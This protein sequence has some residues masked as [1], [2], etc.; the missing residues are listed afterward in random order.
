MRIHTKEKWSLFF[1]A[2]FLTFW[3]SNPVKAQE[4]SDTNS[5]DG[6]LV[7]DPI[8]VE[9]ERTDRLFED[10]W[11]S[12]VIFT[13]E[14]LKESPGTETLNDV[15]RRIPNVTSQGNAT[16]TAPTIRGIDGTGPASGTLAFIGGTLP[17]LNY[18]I[19]GR[20]LSFNEAVFINGSI[21]DAQQVEIYRGPQSTLQGRN[22]IAGVIAVKTMDPS[23]D[24][25][26]I[27]AKAVGGNHDYRH[28][29]AA[30]GGPVVDDVLA[31]RFSGEH[32]AK[33]SF[34]DFQPFAS[35]SDPEAEKFSNARLKVLLQPG[36]NSDFQNLLTIAYKDAYAPQANPVI[37]PFDE[38]VPPS[39]LAAMPRFETKTLEGILDTRW[40]VNDFIQLSAVATATDLEVNRY[41]PPGLGSVEIE[42]TEYT[43]EPR[44]K[45]GNSAD[46]ISGFAAAYLFMADQDEY[47][48]FAGGANFTDETLT[49][50]VFGEVNLN[51]TDRL[52]LNFG[53]RYE[54][55]NRE[56]SG[57]IAI[58]NLNYKE[59]F[60]AFMPRASI[61][62][63]LTDNLTVGAL[64]RRGYNAGGTAITLLPPFPTFEYDSEYVNN[65]EGFVR[66]RLFDDRLDVRANVFY[67][68][69]TDLQVPFIIPGTDAAQ[70]E[71][72]EDASTYG[73]ELEAKFYAHE[74][75]DLHLGLGLLKTKIN[76][77]SGNAS[78]AAGS[79][80]GNELSRAPAFTVGAGFV[81]RPIDDLSIA[82][83]MRYSDA[84]YSD[85]FNQARG[86]IDPYF[87][88]D[89]EISYEFQ[90]ARL[91]LS[92][93]NLFDTRDPT[94]VIFL[95]PNP[96][97]DAASVTTPRSIKLGV[98]VAF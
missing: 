16:N 88:A 90:G 85:E 28:L 30:F 82:F 27:K 71:N 4:N 84:Y 74:K 92:A 61:A 13:E 48:D 70:I 56:R 95:R 73:M 87:T 8:V 83:D 72:V 98:E 23:F 43:I 20:T 64:V 42:G 7:L 24:D 9:G 57:V 51:L 36:G 34:I 96:A 10:T 86:K 81:A 25:W 40:Q 46:R 67:N 97:D 18:T 47:L 91:F 94:S 50:A 17:R 2:A 69:Y 55:E 44:I 45:F 11:T 78:I 31:F 3:I 39:N 29:A 49:R 58:G 12:T 77:F 32:R 75:L 93:T 80:D 33:E 65:F 35:V 21:W 54:V 5:T 63:D 37:R 52:N 53:A 89:A 26:D 38:D 66:T 22:S 14:D 68:D 79:L 41:A 76:D 6:V 15:I 19:D 59:R 1:T 60:S 62:Y